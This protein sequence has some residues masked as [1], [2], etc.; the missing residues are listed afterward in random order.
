MGDLLIALRSVNA[1]DKAISVGFWMTCSAIIVNGPGK[2]VYDVIASL[3]CQFWGSQKVLC[4]LHDGQKLGNYLCYLT[5]SLLG[6][7]ALLKILIWYFCKNLKIYTEREEETASGTEM[8]DL[9]RAAAA[10]P[11]QQREQTNDTNR[12]KLQ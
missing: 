1:Q 4:H 8:Q 3:T 7:C 5:G 12:G 11:K 6:L 10:V 2:I 9:I